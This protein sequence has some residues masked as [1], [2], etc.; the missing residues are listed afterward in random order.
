[1]KKDIHPK[2]DINA[3]ATCAC[4]A[5]FIVG[6]TMDSISV[7]ICSNCHPFFSGTEKIMDSSG[8]VERFN[9]REARSGKKVK[10]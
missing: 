10:N 8:R 7:E 3:K 2:Y 4:G 6:S 5:V 1:M 9:R